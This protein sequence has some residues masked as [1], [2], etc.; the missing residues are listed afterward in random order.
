MSVQQDAIRRKDFLQIVKEAKVQSQTEKK[1][2]NRVSKKEVVR[3]RLV[4]LYLSG[5]YTNR[6]IADILS[7][8]TVTV[9]RM[10]KE[11][12]VIEAI[13]ESQNS[14]KDIIDSKLKSLRDR[15]TDTLSELL[16]S[17]EESVRLQAV[18]M[19][20]DKTGHGDK[21]EIEQNINISYEQQ[22]TQ[23]LEGVSF[24][25]KDLEYLPQGGE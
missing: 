14:E 21:R 3:N 24:D 4:Q 9:G 22:L 7:V 13:K 8:S 19:I 11:P 18:K 1:E 23:V 5:V 15:A 25:V 16:D 12:E 17:E 6:Q 2:Y 10:L 20:L